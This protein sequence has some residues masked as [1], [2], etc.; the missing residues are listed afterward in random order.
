MEYLK[1]IQFYSC[2][3][4]CKHLRNECPTRYTQIC[5]NCSKT[6]QTY[7]DCNNDS[8]CSNCHGPHPATARICP[9]YHT[10]IEMLKPKIAV[11]LAEYIGS[12]NPDDSST[13]FKNTD[14]FLTSLFNSCKSFT[15]Q[16]PTEL[17]QNEDLDD[18][19]FTG[20][21]HPQPDPIT[22]RPHRQMT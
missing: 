21:Q 18:T 8:Y 10:A 12:T 14:E 9:A 1:P 16:R 15:N 17:P 3:V 2:F 11:Q 13:C 7:T 19:R 5:S 6:G 20:T 4:F 22:Q